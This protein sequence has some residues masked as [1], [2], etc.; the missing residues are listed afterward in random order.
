MEEEV[1]GGGKA[2]AGEEVLEGGDAVGRVGAA[3]N[4]LAERLREER[5]RTR[6]QID[7]LSRANRE[8]RAAREDL[9]RSERL[10]SVGRLAAGVAHEV[11]NPVSALIAYA[12]LNLSASLDARFPLAENLRTATTFLTYHLC[13]GA[14]L[15]AGAFNLLTGRWRRFLGR[16]LRP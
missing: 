11:G 2:V 14:G 6:G 7:E 8:I 3:V 15:W 4:R 13:Y 5:Q 9:Q 12:A 16:P 10:A 1:P